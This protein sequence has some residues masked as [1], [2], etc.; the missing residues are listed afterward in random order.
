M[1]SQYGNDFVNE[2]LESIL[3][4]LGGPMQNQ[5][6]VNLENLDLALEYVKGQEGNRGC[7][8]SIII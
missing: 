1:K 5:E 4:S 2:Q 8:E 6:D 3:G 7:C